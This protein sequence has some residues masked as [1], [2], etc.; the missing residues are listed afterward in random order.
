MGVEALIDLCQQL[1]G[2]VQVVL[3]GGDTY[4]PQV[5]GQCWQPGVDITSLS[6]PGQQAIDGE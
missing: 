6:V 3:G 2:R 5:G 4:M 1:G